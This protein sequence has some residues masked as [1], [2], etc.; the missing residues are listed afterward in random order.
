ADLAD[1]GVV[2]A[3]ATRPG[4]ARGTYLFRGSMVHRMA[5]AALDMPVEPLGELLDAASAEE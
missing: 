1:Q 5:A 2:R 3:L 4:L